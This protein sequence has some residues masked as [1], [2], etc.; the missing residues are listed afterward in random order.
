LPLRILEAL[1]RPGLLFLALISFFPPVPAWGAYGAVEVRRVGVSKVEENTLLT[2]VLSRAAEPQVTPRMAM[3]KTQLVVEFP[4]AQGARLPSHVEG[5][6]F[7]VQQ[8]VTEVSPAGVRLILDLYPDVPYTFWRQRRPGVGGGTL[9]ILGLKPDPTARRPESSR[10]QVLP[11]PPERVPGPAAELPSPPLDDYGYQERRATFAPGSF[12]ELKHLIPKAGPLFTSLEGEGWVVS[13]S[14]DYDRPGQ[15]LSRDFV[16]TNRQYPELVVKIANLPANVP[17]VPN[18]NMI[19]LSTE[20]LEGET[21]S[22]YQGMR[23]WNFAKIKEHYE[24]IGDFFDDALKPLRVNL[25]EETKALALKDAQVFQNFL[26]G[27]CPRHPQV[28]E[29]V[30]NH[31]R[32]K[33]N[34]RFEGVQYTISEDPLVILNLVD[35][36]YVRVYFLETG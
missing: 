25:R 1:G 20:N 16:L 19:S 27:A 14:H 36:L 21:V 11:E 15:R 33:V 31:V 26:K 34:Q 13:E 7:L 3:G 10:P 24:D 29:Q 32:E 5:D 28:V 18:I 4:Q 17:N 23:Q 22:K 30:M 35:F 6:D 9:F 2:V 8:V 12:S